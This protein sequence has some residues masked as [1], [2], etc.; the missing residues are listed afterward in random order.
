LQLVIWKRAQNAGE[1]SATTGAAAGM[2]FASQVGLAAPNVTAPV[3]DAE[4]DG[5]DG[6]TKITER[7]ALSDATLTSL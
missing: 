2:T 7:T 3:I 5:G 4:H 1:V 6:G